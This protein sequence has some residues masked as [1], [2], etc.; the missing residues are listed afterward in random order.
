MRSLS[1]DF[2]HLSSVSY[3]WTGE[4]GRIAELVCHLLLRCVGGVHEA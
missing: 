4:N 1:S 2:A 3:G